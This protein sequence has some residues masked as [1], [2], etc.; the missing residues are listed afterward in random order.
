MGQI[1]DIHYVFQTGNRNVFKTATDYLHGLWISKLSNLEKI[2]QTGI[3]DN[4]HQLQHFI[5]DSPWDHRKVMDHVALESGKTFN[6]KKLTGLYLDESGVGKKGKASVGV[7]PQYCGNLGKVDNCQVAVFA[8]IGQGD[9]STIVDSRLYLPKSWT[10]D[11]KRMKKAKIPD[12]AQVFKTK[13]QIALELIE[14]QV[15]IGNRF[16]YINGDALYGADQKLTDAID[17]LSVPFVMDIRENQHIFLEEP[18]IF[19]PPQGARGRKPKNLNANLT[20]IG[21]KEYALSL[22]GKDFKGIKVRNTAKGKLKCRFH[23]RTV[24]IWDKQSPKASKR[25]LVIRKNTKKRKTEMKFA[26]GNVS[27]EKYMPEEI[28]YMQAQRFFIEHSF[29]EAKSVLGLDQFQTRKWI[30][31]YHQV[32][33][34]MLLLLFILKEKLRQFKKMPLLSAYDIRL[35]LETTVVNSDQYATTKIIEVIYQNHKS[36]QRDINRFYSVSSMC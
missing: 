1:A 27:L 4:Y 16:D 3:P 9:F 6:Q 14:H 2:T 13:Q 23:F 31:W 17:E 11:Q 5:S 10:E 7:A 8:A 12:E 28:A 35:I 22:S 36:R 15:S 32:A 19:I 33:L 20:S 26:L 25:M 21:V 18:E 24:W 30:A 34:T 29:K